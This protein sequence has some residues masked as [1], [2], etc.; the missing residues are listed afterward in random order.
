[1]KEQIIEFITFILASFFFLY[2]VMFFLFQKIDIVIH[3]EEEKNEK[4]K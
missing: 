1:M 3:T 2:V 4:T